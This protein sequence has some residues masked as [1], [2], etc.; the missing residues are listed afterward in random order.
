MQQ[1]IQMHW[2]EEGTFMC[3]IYRNQFQIY[4]MNGG[5]LEIIKNVYK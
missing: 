2:S 3:A 4:K 1:P 5:K